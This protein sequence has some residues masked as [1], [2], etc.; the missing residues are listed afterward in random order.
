MSEKMIRKLTEGR[1]YR[2][3]DVSGIELRAGD[4]GEMIV[5]GYATTFGQFYELWRS[6]WY[7]VNEQV[8][9]HS[10]DE[11]DMSDVIFQYNHEGR[12]MAR[13]RNKTLELMVDSH[14]LKIRADLGGT[15]LGRQLYEE[16]KG[17]YTD[18]MSFGFTV[19]TDKREEVEDHETGVTTINRTILAFEKLYD[20]SAV[21]L[22]A[23]DS[24][25]ISARGYADGVI[26][27]LKAL[28]ER[29]EK[30]RQNRERMQE[31]IRQLLTGK[32]DTNR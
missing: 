4:N 14:G 11:C 24:T 25:E 16:I 12:V 30:E 1:E 6:K 29:R 19:K 7:V 8:D 23:N 20:V 21:S 27:E 26:E 28:E 31:E 13:T 5:E 32:K 18:R 3:I 9:G 10:F 2:R 22:P 17:G 15:A